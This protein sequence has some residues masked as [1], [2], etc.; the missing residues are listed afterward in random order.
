MGR[1]VRNVPPNWQHPNL[2]P[3]RSPYRSGFQPMYDEL[4]SNTLAQ[5]LEDFDR[6]RAGNLT[7]FEREVY[8]GT[9]PLAEW[10]QDEGMPPDPAYYR[11][12]TDAEATW[13]QVWETVS[14][15]TP[16]TPPFA[17]KEELVEYLV[18]HGDFWQQQRWNKGE[19]FMQPNPPGY[20]REVAEK[21]VDV[22][23]APSLV[24]IR[25]ETGDRIV[26]GIE[27]VLP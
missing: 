23:W 17:T 10:L 8:T 12:W 5:W 19:R 14:E 20:A 7:E 21:F 24:S 18:T 4:F 22:G 26:E 11:P 16:V 6:I 2:N 3:E 13:F 25:S 15:G 9:F 1:E 27:S